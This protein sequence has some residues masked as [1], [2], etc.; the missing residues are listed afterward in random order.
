MRLLKGLVDAKEAD[1]IEA[2]EIECQHP[3]EQDEGGDEI[4][5][6]LVRSLMIPH[7]H[8]KAGTEGSTEGSQEK[9]CPLGDAP[10]S[11]SSTPLIDAIDDKG[12]G[13][14]KEQEY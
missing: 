8:T 5:E 3:L 14:E 7:D 1:S 12:Q 2:Q 11:S 13:I 10:A 9:E 4:T 6:T